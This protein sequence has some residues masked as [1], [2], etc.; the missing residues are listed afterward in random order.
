MKKFLMLAASVILFVGVALACGDKKD[1]KK[2]KDCCQKEAKAK[3]KEACSKESK[4]K[5]CCKKDGAEKKEVKK[6]EKKETKTEKK[7]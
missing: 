3:N 5:V 2:G 6:E 4:D 1:C 7:A